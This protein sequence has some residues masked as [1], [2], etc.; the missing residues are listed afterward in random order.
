MS[1]EDYTDEGILSLAEYI[2][3]RSR[4]ECMT[5][6]EVGDYINARVIADRDSRGIVGKILQFCTGDSKALYNYIDEQITIAENKRK[7]ELWH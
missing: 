5:S 1:I 4:E 3:K 7:E 6:I 2:L